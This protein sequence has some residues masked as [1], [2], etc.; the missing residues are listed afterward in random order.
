MTQPSTADDLAVA[1]DLADAAD[2]ISLARFHAADLAVD[3]K[4]DMTPVSDADIAVE[5]ALR[6]ILAERRPGDEIVGEEFGG[7]IPPAERA[8]RGRAW[9]IDPIDGTKNY[10]RG[11]PVWATLIALLVD[12]SPVLGVVSA[13]ALARR[14]WGA[15]ESGA[16]TSFAGGAARR[17]EVSGVAE[18]ADASLSISDL[19]EWVS[20][21]RGEQITALGRSCWRSRGYGDFFSYVLVAEG[22]VDIA[23]EPELNLWDLAALGPIVTAA[24]GVFTTVDGTA[25]TP[26]ATSALASNGRVHGAAVA[27]LAAG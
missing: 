25:I 3:T 8:A 11:V 13:P 4:P 15:P 18:I 20:A 24:G 17:C 9:V 1:L 19:E 22:A 23:A 5:K 12:G 21:G 6:A 14:W 10:V 16:W 7:D 26:S 2:A 27:A